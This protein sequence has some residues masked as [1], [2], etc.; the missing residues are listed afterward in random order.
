MKLNDSKTAHVAEA[1]SAVLSGKGKEYSMDRLHTEALEINESIKSV[2]E[3]A[4]EEMDPR[5][6]VSEKDGKFVVVNRKG[7][8]V[9]SFDNKEEAEEYAVSNHDSLMK[10]ATDLE[11]A[12]KVIAQVELWNGKKMKKSFKDQSSAEEFIKKMQDQE[13]VRGYNMYA[14]GLEE[15]SKLSSKEE[16]MV[17]KVVGSTKTTKEAV[18]KVAKEMKLSAKEAAVIVKELMDKYESA[19]A[20]E[21]AE[22]INE[23]K[24]ITIKVPWNGPNPWDV[25][26]SWPYMVNLDDWDRREREI[27]ISGPKR[28]IEKWFLDDEPEGYGA[29][30]SQVRGLF[31]QISIE[32]PIKESNED[33]KAAYKAFFAKA[34][35]KFGIDDITDLKGDKKKEFFDYV[36]ANWKAKDE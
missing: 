17:L 9:K 20:D 19:E 26:P 29:S 27:T 25:Q 15:A 12:K 24:E 4:Q 30:R 2:D 33:D 8:E 11:E 13:D 36:D 21:A 3:D 7:E 6:H 35:K 28:E 34:M 16:A 31:R 14:E 10:E 22:E 32:N 5:D 18:A 1:V 23:A